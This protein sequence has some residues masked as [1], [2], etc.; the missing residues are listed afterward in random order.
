VGSG[1]TP[2]RLP[3]CPHNIFRGMALAGRRAP[4]NR[5][6]DS[7]EMAAGRQ[8]GQNP[9]RRARCYQHA[10][11]F[12]QGDEMSKKNKQEDT[13]CNEQEREQRKNK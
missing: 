1:G 13:P 7:H 4:S 3:K 6:L 9:A 10:R 8:A 5:E 2:E 12:L 11:R